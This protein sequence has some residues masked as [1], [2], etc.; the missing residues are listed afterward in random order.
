MIAVFY[1]ADILGTIIRADLNHFVGFVL[2]FAWVSLG[3]A[4]GTAVF[5][6]TVALGFKIGLLLFFSYFLVFALTLFLGFVI[7]KEKF[8]KNFEETTKNSPYIFEA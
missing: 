2:Q 7:R 4:I 6:P 3:I 5:A 1:L 8:R